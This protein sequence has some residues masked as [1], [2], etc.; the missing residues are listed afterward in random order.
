MTRIGSNR[1]KQT[2]KYPVNNNDKVVQVIQ[3]FRLR[4]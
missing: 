2:S 4:R 1:K 3:E